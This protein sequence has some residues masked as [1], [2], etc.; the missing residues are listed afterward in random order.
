MA[1]LIQS[2]QIQGI[3]TASVIEG[4]FAVNAGSVNLAAASGVTGSFSGS[5]VGDGSGIQGI[6]YSQID[7]TPVF[8]PG[9]NI[10]ITSGSNIITITST[11]SGGGGSNESLNSFTASYYTDSSSFDSRIVGISA[12]G[13]GA[14]WNTNLQN[15]PSNLISGSIQILGGT[16]IISSSAQISSLGF[17]TSS[18]TDISSLNDY[19][20]SNDLRLT[21]L[22][23]TTS[24]LDTRITQ[25][26][27]STGSYETIGRG[28]ISSSEQFPSGLVSGSEQ[29]LGGTGILSGSHSDLS[30]LNTYTSSTDERL[31]NIEAATGSYL[32]SETDSQTLSI[33]GDQL[34]I[35]TGN[36]VTIPTGSTA[37]AGT[38]SGSEQITALGFTSGSHTDIPS[39]T[40]SGSQQITDLGFIS[41]SHTDVTSLNT[42]TSSIQTEV[43]AI[44]SVTSS[45]LTQTPSGTISGSEQVDFDVVTGGKGILSGS[46]TDIDSLNTFTSSIQTELDALSAATSSYLTSETDSQTLSISGDQLTISSGNTITIPSGSSGTTDYTQ[47]TNVPSGLVS[48]SS[49]VDYDVLTGGKGLLSGSHTDISSLNDYTSSTDTR[50]SGIDSITSSLEQRVSEIE[51][52]TGS[53]DDLTNITHLNTF[54]SSYYT[55]SASFDTQIS[56][57]KGRIDNILS[58]ANADY[59]QFVEIVNLVNSTDAENDT[60]FANHYTSSRQRLTALETFTSSIDTSIKSKLDSDGVFSGSLVA[61]ENITINVDGSNYIISSSASGGSSNV[62]VS[63]SA[64]SSP[65]QGDLWWKSDDGNL[66]VYYDGYWVIS[67][68]TTSTLPSGVISGSSQLTSSY[69]TRYSLSGSSGVSDY[70]DLTNIPANIISGSQQITDLGFISSSHTVIDSL[71]TFT[72]SIQTEVDGLSATTSSYLTSLDGGIISGSSQITALGFVSSSGDNTPAGTISGSQQIT[73]LGFISSSDSTTSLNTFTSSIQTEVDGLSAATSSYLTSSGSVDFTD[74]TSVPSGIISGSS[75]LTSSYDT[76]YALSG[77]GGGDTDF[78]GNRIVSQEKLPTMFTSSFNPGTSGSVVDFLNAVFYP[79]SDPAITSGNHTISEYSSSGSPIFTLEAT[80]PE[81][82]ALT[83]G[84]GSTYTDDLVRVASNGVV[85]LNAVPTS[86]SFN[87]DLVGGS[88]GHTFIAKATDTFNSSIEKDITIFVTPNST[89][90]FRETSISGNVITSVTSNLN[91]S[92]ADDTLLKRVFFTDANG[93]T[94]TIHSSSIDGNHFEVIKSSTYV[95]ILQNTGSLNYEEQTTYNF[96]ISASDEHYELGQDSDSI[97]VL[98]ITVNVTDNL[99]PTI[100]N[101]SLSSINENSSDGTTVGTISA[102]DNEGD[103]ITFANFTLYKLELDNVNV[104]SGSY[105]GTSQLTDP[106]ENPFQ[107]S[108]SGVVT[109]KVGVYLNSDL[110]NEYQY[111]VEVKDSYNESSNP[112]IITIQIDDDTP[113][114]ISDNWSAGPYIKESEENGTTIKT[115]NYGSTTADYN[116]N[117][118]GTFTSSNP[119]IVINGSG[120]LSLGVDLSGSVT[121]SDDSLDSVITFTNTFGTITTDNLNVDIVHNHHPSASFT[122]Q[123]SNLNTNLATTN[124]NL[125]LVSITDTE[126]DTPYSA[127]LS[128]TDAGKLNLNY[129]NSNSSSLYIRANENLSA[130]TITYNLRVSDSYSEVSDYIGNTISINDV[131]TGTLGGDTTSHIIESA[132]NNDSLRD[133]SGFEGGNTSQLTVSYSGSDGTPSVQS[134]TSSNPS[135]DI[136]SSGNL[137]LAVDISGSLTSSGDT[138]SSDITFQ[139]N[140]GNVGSGSLTVNVFGN[141]HPSASFTNNSGVYNTNQATS[142]ALITSL[143]ITDEE[144]DTPFSMS[145]SGT[146]ANKFNIEPQNSNTSSI[147]LTAASDFDGGTYS[148]TASIFDQFGETSQYEREITIAEADL[149]TLSTNGTFYVIESAVNG[150]NIVTNSNGRTGTQGDLGVSYSP[151]YGSQV[152]QEF[153]SSNAFVSVNSS[154]NLS[155]GTNISGSSETSGDSITS[156]ITWADQHGNV[157]SGSISVNVTTNNAPTTSSVSTQF[158]NTNQASGSIQ[159]LELTITDTESDSI[160]NS[161]LTWTSYN[162]TY[163]SP[164]ISSPYMR[165]SANNIQVPSGNYPWSASLQDEHGFNTTSVN[166]ILTIVQSDTGTLGG[167]TSVYAIESALSGSVLRDATGFENGNVGDV[168]VSYS[169]SFGSPIVQSFT[170]SNAAIAVNDTGGLT[171]AVDLSGSLTQSGDTVSTTITFDDQYGNVG[172]GSVTL[173]VFGNQSPVASFTSSSNYESDN[174]VADS[175]AGTLVVTDVESNSPF[176]VT[177]AGTDG[178]KFNVSGSTSPFEIQPTGS[179]EAGTYS[180]NIVVTDTYSESVTLSNETITVDASGNTGKVYIYYSNYASDGNYSSA[181]NAVMGASTLNSDT[182]PEVTAYTANTASPYYKIKTSVGD[183]SYSLAG[184]KT[185]TLA[186]TISGSD[187]PTIISASAGNMSWGSA[188]QTVF[189]IPSGS[190]MTNVPTS[191]TDGF[192]GST[193]GE[194]CL[195]HYADGTSAP[196]GPSPSVIHTLDVDGTQGGFDK[197]HVLGAAINSSAT[198]MRVKVIPSS[199]SIGAF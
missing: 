152:V 190:S 180:I 11:A 160:P 95:D 118:S 108:S 32:T 199:G 41:S 48:G 23:S 1:T 87:T 150:N 43:D 24:S 91:E 163:F 3:V 134:F 106:H 105:G 33:S 153:T 27:D 120:N 109:R 133:A 129:T 195:V 7:N 82:Q 68:D 186:A 92:S 103:T 164:S 104:S 75:Q 194:Y 37:V 49:Q 162:T 178:G 58:G 67:L 10:T 110:I 79:N 196:L 126:G 89:P 168:D 45:Y 66:Y 184:G 76:R 55:D 8:L 52:N 40:I 74:I 139:D 191:M 21:N 166:G 119:A 127:S 198:N 77:S 125:V 175:D 107:M 53:Y 188:V 197:W 98:P 189:V 46:K 50:L 22:E 132:R 99:V 138:I 65:S 102:A 18:H 47:L 56:T 96:S 17:L 9:N 176:T 165:L 64:P 169:P 116:S 140:Y 71:N 86:A 13:S 84:T 70:T 81:G 20:S 111:T 154:G 157:G 161:G 130:G 174:A 26:S 121:Q 113:A 149:G 19:T 185:M 88:H 151:N 158:G 93:D 148:Y 136:D 69:D 181:Y 6:D 54:T 25:L 60:A 78:D 63:D 73:D 94:I 146:D 159:L 173:N 42:F 145:L 72:S 182:P 2:K 117:Q 114:I 141:S 80:D 35:S 90:V 62:T 124:T 83:F 30:S 171:L 123:N 12:S 15:I 193:V 135:I 143:T 167:D 131:D 142:S 57:E 112:A 137:T 14:D 155:V 100:S 4:D 97:V 183:S 128:G 28:I 5:F 16:D 85:T 192:G 187:F 170:S 177:L 34:T 144:S 38:I 44:S 29:I 51:S 115:T 179:L 101:Q 36:T 156:N 31:S 172:S 122:L 39:G 61:G 59:D 147:Q